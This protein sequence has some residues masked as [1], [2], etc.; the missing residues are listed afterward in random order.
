MDAERRLCPLETNDIWEIYHRIPFMVVSRNAFVSMVLHCPP[1]ISLKDGNSPL[2]EEMEVLFEVYWKPWLIDV[3]DWLQCFGIAPWYWRTI[4]GTKHRVPAVPPFGSGWITTYFDTKTHAQ[5]FRWYSNNTHDNGFHF[6]TKL[7]PPL[8]TGFHQSSVSSLLSDWRTFKIAR[9]SL[10]IVFYRQAHQQHV[11]EHH[12]PK[13]NI[14][15]DN[16]TTLES[17]GDTIAATVLARQEGLTNQKMTIRSDYLQDAMRQA[18]AHNHGVSSRFGKTGTPTIGTERRN[19]VW[20]RENAGTVESALPLKPDFSCK[21]VP[22]P[23]VQADLAQI[24]SRLDHMASAIMDIPISVIEAIGGKT[25]A[26]VA[27]NFRFLNERIKDW[28]KYFETITKKAFLFGYGKI[29]QDDF[30]ARA[31]KLYVDTQIEVEM[32]CTPIANA[33]DI[34]E[35]HAG[36]WM[37]KEAAGIHMFN[38]LG[39]PLSDMTVSEY[40]DMVPRELVVAPQKKQKVEKKDKVL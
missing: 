34:K 18:S 35:L 37:T 11:L 33:S 16:L 39:I 32:P 26:S 38:V 15:D 8:L 12:P 4:K 20:E 25:T 10:E 24:A 40:P 9:E 13:N 14:G 30:N 22:S 1:R 2:S 5:G 7:R 23:H 19:D 17:F 3:Y 31:L 36:G 29:L 27:G 21:T 28:Q 6:E